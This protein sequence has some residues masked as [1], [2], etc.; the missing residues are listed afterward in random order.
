M[1]DS[2]LLAGKR[3]LIAEDEP[4]LALDLETFG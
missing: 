4:L 3:V 1:A 2:E